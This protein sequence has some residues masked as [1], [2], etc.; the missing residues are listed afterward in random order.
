MRTV[1]SLIPGLRDTIANLS[2][3]STIAI[4]LILGLSLPIALSA[5][6][7]LSERRQ[8]LWASMANTGEW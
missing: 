7:N 3:R 2:L 5:W 6:W 4:A 1:R 8:E